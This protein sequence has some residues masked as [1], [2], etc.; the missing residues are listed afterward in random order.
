MTENE[1]RPPEVST[2]VA[3]TPDEVWQLIATGPGISRWF[4]PASVEPHVGGAI[5][6]RHGPGDD[7]VSRGTIST[8][9]PPHRFVYEEDWEGRTMATEFLFEARS[10]GSCVVRVVTHGLTADDA[11]FAGGLVS[12]W[13]QVLAILRVYLATFAGQPAGSVRLW[14]R[15]GGALDEAWSETLRRAGLLGVAVGPACR[16][17]ERRAIHRRRGARPE[18]RCARARRCSTSR[19][20]QLHCDRLRRP[21]VRGRLPLHLR[22]RRSSSHRRRRAARLGEPSPHG[23][24]SGQLWRLSSGGP[25]T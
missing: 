11:D 25:P 23:L 2:V 21:D 24:T 16:E 17:H 10:G 15:P 12:G 6:Q 8:Y 7:D 13:T 3:G 4:V 14:T 1:A 9:E 18:T 22:R 19:C 20:A 5:T